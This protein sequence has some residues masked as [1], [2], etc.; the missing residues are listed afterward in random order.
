MKQ[1]R[2]RAFAS[3]QKKKR[4]KRTE[5]LH[6]VKRES[7][8]AKPSFA[9]QP[10]RIQQ[11]QQQQQQQQRGGGGASAAATATVAHGDPSSLL[12]LLEASASSR[13]LSSASD[14][15]WTRRVRRAPQAPIPPSYP[16]T[17][18]DGNGNN[19][20]PVLENPALF[21]RLDAD[22]LFFSFYHQQ[23]TPQQYLAARELK[24]ANW[25]FHK[26]I[27]RLQG[28]YVY[29]DH[30]VSR[31]EYGSVRGWCQRSKP[32]FLFEYSHLENELQ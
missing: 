29:F 19:L 2:A 15:V 3:Y 24:R 9:S 1:K 28:A 7:K 22:A 27:R 4:K 11:Q 30:A 5:K 18:L 17:L 20:Y 8:F 12:R 25:L 14:G 16:T 6:F 26:K 32:D 13:L 31:D 23:G 21:E 10:S